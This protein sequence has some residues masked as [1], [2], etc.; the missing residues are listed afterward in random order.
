MM[1]HARLGVGVEGVAIAE[2]A[3]Q[4]ALEYA[5]TRVQG[6]AIGQRSGDR[7]TIIHHPD[8][9]RMLLTMKAQTEAMRA[10]AYIA[11]AALDKAQHH[12]DAARAAAQPGAASIS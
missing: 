6:R 10:L 3:Y 5:R 11:A 4:H 9:R 2:R 1:N 7:V 12:P 8:V